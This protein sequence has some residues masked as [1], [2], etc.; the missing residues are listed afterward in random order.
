V[1]VIAG[2]L[3]G[4]RLTSGGADLRPSSGRLREALFSILEPRIAGC[5]FLDLYAGTGAVAIEALSRGASEAVLVEKE[6]GAC[7]AI[8][9]NLEACGVGKVARLVRADALSALQKMSTRGDRFDLVFADP[10]Y[11]YPPLPRLL[12]AIPKREVLARDGL[13]ILE[14]PWGEEVGTPAGLR[15]V[16]LQRYGG[17]GLAFFEAS[18]A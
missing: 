13:F 10:P 14:R 1:R 18:D 9:R 17:S 2:S 8:R 5:R 4:T 7:R 15:R 3:K 11:G 6:A 12:K 16:R